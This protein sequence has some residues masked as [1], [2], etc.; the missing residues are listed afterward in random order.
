MSNPS[1]VIRVAANIAE[2]KKNLAE[3][4]DAI[5]VTTAGMQKLASSLDGS[6]LFQQANNIVAAVESI[7][8]ADK[9]SAAEQERLNAVLDRA[10]EKYAALGR[11]APT[12][13][14]ELADATRQADD[15]TGGLG[16]RIL[17]TAAGF[18]SA[19]VIFEAAKGAVRAVADELKTITIGGAA[20]ADVEENFTRLTQKAGLLGDTLLGTLRQGTHNTITDFDLMKTVNQ[21]LAAGV[22][23]TDQQFGTLAKGAF[24]LAQATGGDVKTALDTMNDAMLTGRTRSLALLTGKIDQTAAEEAYAAKLGTTREHLTEE[25]KLEANREA[26]LNSVAAATG[27][28]G[29]QT[30]GLDERLAQA[31]VWWENLENNLGKTIATSSVLEAGMSTLKQALVDTFGGSDEA[32]IR[33]IARAVDGV[34]IELVSMAQDGVRAGGFLTEEFFAIKKLFGDLQQVVDGDA[35]ALEYL[36]LALAKSLNL[37]TAG[38]AFRDDI[39]RINANIDSLLVTMKARGDQLQRDDQAQAGVNAR[40]EQFTG[41]LEQVR[42]RMEAARQG[43]DAGAKANAG[44]ADSSRDAADAAGEHGAQVKQTADEIKRWNDVVAE[45]TATGE[46]WKGTL[47]T[48]NGSVAEGVKYYLQAGVAQ[49]KLATFYGL[50]AAQIKAVASQ[51]TDEAA[52]QKIADQSVIESTKVWDQYF[53]LRVQHGGTA[54]DAQ[55]AQVEAWEDA[56]L[57]KLKE[58][59]SNYLNHYN[60]ITAY[61]DEWRQSV[62]VDWKTIADK[63]DATLQQR[64]ANAEATYQFMVAHS[65][66]FKNVDIDNQRAIAD[67]ARA[68]AE[69]WSTSYT[70]AGATVEAVVTKTTQRALL[71][72]NQAMDLVRDGLGTMSGTLSRN[73]DVS[74]AHRA[75]IQSDFNAG[76]YFGPVTPNGQPDFAALGFQGRAMGGDVEAGQPYIVNERGGSELFRDSLGHQMFIPGTSG[77]IIPAGGA[78]MTLNL[79]VNVDGR[80]SF[81]DTPMGMN[82]LGDVVVGAVLSKLRG[83]GLAIG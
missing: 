50:T 53:A 20:V 49:D 41:I 61:A 9:L 43:A 4:G 75:Q 28:L 22:V 60:A 38:Q 72:F 24:A 25:A 57:A 8:G 5:N 71:T 44:V 59:D 76:H 32:L 1:L 77:T 6:K 83:R 30:D 7:G 45:V 42:A 18:L 33:S 27:R 31:Q 64:A 66:H 54:V 12:G 13:M 2:L 11:T 74:A 19:Q 68:A 29:D 69:S 79:T 34:A 82:R 37:A 23:L 52:A 67:A 14:R 46:G 65:E 40:V 80:D 48:I 16:A 15:T 26:I 62:L 17:E 78:G 70:E 81:Y 47:D 73:T 35:L 3:G 10:L 21:D 55:L 39:T 56:E 51:L 63:S 36:S 58:S